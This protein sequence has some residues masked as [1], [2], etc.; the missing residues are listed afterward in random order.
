[1]EIP[2]EKDRDQEVLVVAKGDVTLPNPTA[3]TCKGVI[4][5]GESV[6]KG[7]Y[8]VTPMEKY[9]GVEEEVTLWGSDKGY[10]NPSHIDS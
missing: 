4:A 3:L 8:Q 1:M 5:T 9:S 2:L 7:P 10:R 6:E